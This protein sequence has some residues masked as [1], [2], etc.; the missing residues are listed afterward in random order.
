MWMQTD[1]LKEKFQWEISQEYSSKQKLGRTRT[2]CLSLKE[3]SQRLRRKLRKELRRRR[4]MLSKSEFFRKLL[5]MK[6]SCVSLLS[7]KKLMTKS[8]KGNYLLIKL[9]KL[10]K[11]CPIVKTGFKDSSKI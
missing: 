10:K 8:L 9:R 1:N 5:M 3:L 7:N 6:R 11:I 2:R 4:P